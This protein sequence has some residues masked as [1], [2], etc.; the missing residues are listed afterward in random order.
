METPEYPALLLHSR[1]V[2]KGFSHGR[3][4]LGWEVRIQMPDE[5]SQPN[6]RYSD[7]SGPA[8]LAAFTMHELGCWEDPPELSTPKAFH[9][10][11]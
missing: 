1:A 4:P 10:A 2:F 11:I 5:A 8:A 3:F 6:R 7:G 9:E